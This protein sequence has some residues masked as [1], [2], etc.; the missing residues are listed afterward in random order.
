MELLSIRGQSDLKRPR[1]ESN[2]LSGLRRHPVY[3][4]S[5]IL[6]CSVQMEV[7]LTAALTSASAITVEMPRRPSPDAQRTNERRTAICIRMAT[8][9][10]NVAVRRVRRASIFLL[11]SSSR[12][13]VGIDGIPSEPRCYFAH[14]V[15]A[16]DGVGLDIAVLFV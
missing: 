2:S 5:A 4:F 7:S 12:F 16:Q 11:P 9:E 3:S 10:L 15:F 13:R 1:T 14:V 6:L 8:R